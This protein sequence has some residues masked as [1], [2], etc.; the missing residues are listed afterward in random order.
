MAR[1]QP[2][3]RRLAKASRF[4]EDFALQFDGE[5]HAFGIDPRAAEHPLDGDGPKGLE[6]RLQAFGVHAR[7]LV[8]AGA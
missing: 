7:L 2:L 6:Q 8:Q 1:N 4:E 3:K 5:A